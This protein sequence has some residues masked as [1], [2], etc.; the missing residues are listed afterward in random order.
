MFKFCGKS[1]WQTRTVSDKCYSSVCV[2]KIIPATI[3]VNE[4]NIVFY[5]CIAKYG[6]IFL[7]QNNGEY[8]DRSQ[9][10][11][12]LLSVNTAQIKSIALISDHLF[13]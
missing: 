12:I 13:V 5:I 4:S 7:I 9:C 2:W 3:Q 8:M 1:E 6:L 10:S 11:I